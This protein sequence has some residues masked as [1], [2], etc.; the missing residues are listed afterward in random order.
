MRAG[1]VG[2]ALALLLVLPTGAGSGPRRCPRD[3]RLGAVAFVR[4]GALHVVSLTD[5]RDRVLVARGANPPV[6][7]SRDGRSIDYGNH[8][9]VGVNGGRPRRV[10]PPA[11]L[12]SP[13]GRLMAEVRSRR[14]PHAARGTQAI[15]IRDRRGRG[16]AVH[17]VRESYRGTPAGSPGP[18]GL[19]GWSPDSRWLLFYVDPLGSASLAAD[20]VDVKVIGVQGGRPRRVARML[21]YRDYIAWCGRRLIITA[22]GSRLAT[23]QKW[24]A[25]AAAPRWRA[26]R[27][28]RAQARAWGSVSCSARGLAVQSQPVSHDYNFTHM[29]WSI[30]LV[31]LD[32]SQRRLTAAPAGFADDSPRWVAGGRA[33]LFVRSR[34]GA[35]SLYAWQS[36]RVVGPIISL[37]FNLGYYGHRDWWYAADWSGGPKRR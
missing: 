21:L 25:V 12:A 2:L 29:R 11:G 32:G 18:L 9:R 30:W 23:E 13:D 6:R 14:R 17:T 4:S 37:G 27:L 22:G 36:G 35:G 19:V 33:L 26:R 16:R 5:C 15:W 20:G 7:F 10:T 31:R 8:W 34:R 1:F 3:A 24:L 28:V